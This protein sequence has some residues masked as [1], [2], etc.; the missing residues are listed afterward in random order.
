MNEH[1]LIKAIKNS[2]AFA[3]KELS[4]IYYQQLYGFV[5]RRIGNSDN[6]KD[7][8]QDLFLNIWKLRNNLD[9]NRPIKPYLFASANNLVKN[10]LKRKSLKNERMT[11]LHPDELSGNI[12]NENILDNYLDEALTDI[13]E[14]LRI[15]FIM[16]KFE[17][18]KYSEIAEMLE[19]SEKTV[20]SRMSKILKFLRNKFSLLV[21]IMT[22]AFIFSLCIDSV[23]TLF[24][25][26]R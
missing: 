2:D 18:F 23:F 24:N 10:H 25:C 19:I 20:E 15:V 11:D 4:K 14:R 22:S 8:L 9:E 26:I 16:N 1:E 3:F 5:W 17:G 13:P 21:L 7:L 6:V 12:G